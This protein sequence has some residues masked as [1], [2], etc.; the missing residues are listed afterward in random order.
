M[1]HF[2][3]AYS[4]SADGLV[5]I[6]LGNAEILLCVRPCAGAEDTAGTVADNLKNAHTS[7]G[8]GRESNA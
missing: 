3:G 6:S 5:V 2:N 8:F 1:K 7:Q 4:D